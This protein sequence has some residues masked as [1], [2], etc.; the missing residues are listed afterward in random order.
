[1]A[2]QP[3][4]IAD[5]RQGKQDNV[6]PWLLPNQAFE[7]LTN[8]VVKNGVLS[9][10]RG[11]T[12]YDKFT[13]YACA[14]TGSGSTITA[15]TK[16]SPCQITVSAATSWL[17]GQKIQIASVGGM[18]E[19]N[20][21][22]YTIT[23]VDSTHFT[24]G[25]DSSAYGVYTSGGKA[26]ALTE[27]DSYVI[28]GI[29]KAAVGVVT[30]SDPHRLQTGNIVRLVNVGGMTELEG[31]ELTVTVVTA[32]TFS[33]GIATTTYT[34]F[35]SGGEVHKIGSDA[36]MGIMQYQTSSDIDELIVCSETRIAK[37]DTSAELIVPIQDIQEIVGRG[38]GATATYT[39]TLVNKPIVCGSLVITDGV[40]TATDD[41]AGGFTGD[42]SAGA[43]NYTTGVY[44]VTFDANITSGNAVTASYDCREAIFA[45]GSDDF[46]SSENFDAKL[47]FT[48]GVDRIK[49]WNGTTLDNHIF[50]LTNEDAESNEINT[51]LHIKALRGR[52]ILFLTTENSTQYPQRFR[53][54]TNGNTDKWWTGTGG[55][56]YG[57]L[58]TNDFI[59]VAGYI[60]DNIGVVCGKSAY[61]LRYTANPAMPFTVSRINNYRY[62]D[63]P[64]SMVEM[65]NGIIAI[66]RQGVIATDGNTVREIDDLI[67]N[68]IEDNIDGSKFYNVNGFHIEE[69]RQV[70]FAYPE[71]GETT[72]TA[73]LCYNYEDGAWSTFD[74]GMTC[75]GYHKED[76]DLGFADFPDETFESFA[77]YAWDDFVFAS[78]PIVLGGGTDG[79]IYK[80]NFT[81]ADNGTGFDVTMIGK[82]WNP[83]SDIGKSARLGYVDFLVSVTDAELEIAFYESTQATAYQTK[84]VVCDS[85]ANQSKVWKRLYSGA[86]SDFHRI[87][88]TDT[89]ST[90]VVNIH[91]IRLW[92]EPVG[93]GIGYGR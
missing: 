27:A 29:S 43:I 83:F 46:F 76:S 72:S 21:N 42:V 80:M 66:G 19:L 45:G 88:I 56:S 75:F 35:T 32:T 81:N 15:A 17:S 10:R 87:G 82:R 63:S 11:Y 64:Y 59:R 8:A 54:C 9:K 7:T 78:A 89:T 79:V 3:F 44:S 41:G 70:W 25:V 49:T 48:N 55:G 28:A 47:W 69:E 50:D 33:I 62:C 6:E 93:R 40:K 23:K 86:I 92:M 31:V 5:F 34:T 4:L 67:P 53:W 39:G 22:V 26:Y 20:G 71:E 58:D 37:Y 85:D 61:T 2:Y 84:T 74:F 68:Y 24:L 14:A 60:G 16:A 1:M 91:A 18:T 77:D 12:E 13:E 36:I 51:C 65:D 38:D 73:V 30:T 57:D 52:L 90:N